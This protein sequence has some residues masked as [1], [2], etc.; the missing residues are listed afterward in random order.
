MISKSGA[1]FGAATTTRPQNRQKI[2]RRLRRQVDPGGDAGTRA[3]RSDD[4]AGSRDAQGAPA[5]TVWLYDIAVRFDDGSERWRVVCRDGSVIEEPCETPILSAAS[6]MLF[7]TEGK[8]GVA[9]RRVR[10]VRAVRATDCAVA[11]ARVR[12]SGYRKKMTSPARSESAPSC[13]QEYRSGGLPCRYRIA[14]RGGTSARNNF[15][16]DPW[17][18]DQAAVSGIS[19]IVCSL[20]PPRRRRLQI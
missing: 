17:R 13:P 11:P 20:V 10:R 2:P 5:M 14:Q 16:A 19:C 6:F 12:S 15:S 18:V 3:C 7:L 4:V 8:S 9:F 1:A